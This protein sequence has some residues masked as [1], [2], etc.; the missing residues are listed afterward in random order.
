MGYKKPISLFINGG[1]RMVVVLAGGVGGSK[2]IKGLSSVTEK[3]KAIIN[4]GDDIER[5][6]LHISPDIDINLY[7]LA[8]V[9]HEQGWGFE[10]ETYACQQ[11]LDEIYNQ[12]CWFNIGDRDLATHIYRTHLLKKGYTL[13]QITSKLCEYWGIPIEMI[14][15]SDDP[16]K[17]YIVTDNGRIHFQEYL[18]KRKM[19]DRVIDIVFEGKDV[20]KPTPGIIETI[21]AAEIIIF[22]PSNPL[23]SIGPILSMAGMREAIK[24]SP[25]KVVAISP[26]IGGRVIKGPADKMMKNLGIEVSP[27]GVANHYKGLLDAIVIDK[28]DTSYSHRLEENG[29]CVLVTD[30]IVNSDEKKTALA[31]QVVDWTKQLH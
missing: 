10:G 27:V 5:F 22:A 15:M 20:A 31:K 7:T 6:G 9:I 1:I 16:I 8:N 11:V 17:T 13:S 3:V 21:R 24:E 19:E 25:A 29:L 18:V 12:E 28:Q 23:V 14:P 4:T 2:L 30:T 26:I